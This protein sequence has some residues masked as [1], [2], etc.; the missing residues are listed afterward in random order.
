MS[1]FSPTPWRFYTKPCRDRASPGRTRSSPSARS[2]KPR[3][4]WGKYGPCM[5]C[6]TRRCY[7]H[8]DGEFNTTTNHIVCLQARLFILNFSACYLYSMLLSHGSV[9][10]ARKHMLFIFTDSG[11]GQIIW[12]NQQLLS[13]QPALLKLRVSYLPNLLRHW[14]SNRV[15][16]EICHCLCMF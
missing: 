5:E 4:W 9:L 13:S 11:C 7:K 15:D 3:L 6:S 8:R 10:A 12:H 14:D 16:R 2:L 1:S